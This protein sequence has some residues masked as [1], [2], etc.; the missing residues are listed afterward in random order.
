[1]AAGQ[2]VAM[3]YRDVFW[4]KEGIAGWQKTH[5]FIESSDYSY[6]RRKI[7]AP[8]TARELQAKLQNDTRYVLVDIRDEKSR[9]KLGSIAGTALEFPV[10]RLHLDY[11]DL[12]E[13][14]ILVLYDIRAKQAPAAIRYLLKKRFYFINLTYLKG[15]VTAWKDEG[16]PMAVP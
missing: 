13:D 5:N 12:P 3:G 6:A 4:Y 2:A 15:G 8:L 11:N 7:P 14:K 10:Y 16:L 1:M 9:N